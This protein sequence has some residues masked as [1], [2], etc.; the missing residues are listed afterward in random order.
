MRQAMFQNFQ[1][2]RNTVLKKKKSLE[3]EG[4]KKKTGR[5]RGAG[6]LQQEVFHG[7][8]VMKKQLYTEVLIRSAKLDF[9]T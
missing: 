4:R 1:F 7:H 9:P 3:L 2:S 6:S 8:Q 5:G